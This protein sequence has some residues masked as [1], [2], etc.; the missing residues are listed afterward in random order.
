MFF[1]KGQKLDEIAGIEHNQISATF[2]SLA[3]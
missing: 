1:K 2:A 3:D